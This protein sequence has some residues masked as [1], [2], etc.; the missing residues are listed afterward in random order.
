MRRKGRNEEE[1]EREECRRVKMTCYTAAADGRFY[2]ENQ[3][4][5]VITPLSGQPNALLCISYL[6]KVDQGD[7]SGF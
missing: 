6:D 4:G 1:E 7:S 2:A 5:C 3:G